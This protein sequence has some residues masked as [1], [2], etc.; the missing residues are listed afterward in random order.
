MADLLLPD[1]VATILKCT[2]DRVIRMT[3]RREIAHVKDGGRIKFTRQQVDD[4]IAANTIPAID[5]RRSNPR[6]R[7]TA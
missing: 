3:Q 7:K 6:N 5:Y 4:Y 1:D 2:R